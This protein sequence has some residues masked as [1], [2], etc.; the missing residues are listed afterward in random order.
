MGK[1]SI[2]VISFISITF[3][4]YEDTCVLIDSIFLHIKSIS[5][6]IIIVDNA[7]HINEAS[8]I[9]NKYPEV[10]TIRS[11][12]NLGFSGGNNLG[13]KKARGKFI[14]LINNDTYFLDDGILTLV[15]KLKSSKYIAG[16]S[17]KIKFAVPPY[18]V[19]F[20]GFTKLSTVTL[21]NQTIGYGHKDDGTYNTSSII[22]YLHG[23]AMMLKREVIEKTGLMPEI[24]FLYYEELDW[25]TQITQ[26]GYEFWYEPECTIYHKESQSTGKQSKLQVFYMTRN[27]L[28]YAWRNLPALAKYMSIIYQLVIANTKNILILLLKGKKELA[29]SV[30]NGTL[31]FFSLSNKKKRYNW[32]SE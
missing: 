9:R 5:Y 15:N 18:Y 22:P 26:A 7:S 16:V 23:A 4:G 28:L 25:C 14:F 19:Q 10:E 13:I 3:N 21:R 1:A 2:P 31:A 32:K 24:Y 27:R 6:E 17:P 30:F 8:L 12:T 11:E 20:A 29:I